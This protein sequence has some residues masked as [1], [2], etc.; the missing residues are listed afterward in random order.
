MVAADEISSVKTYV[1]M[2]IMEHEVSGEEDPRTPPERIRN[3][4]IQVGIWRRRR[5][6]GYHWRSVVII[7]VI[8]NLGARTRDRTFDR[9]L[10]LL[11]SRL[12][13]RCEMSR[14]SNHFNPIPVFLGN[15]FVLVGEMNDP[16]FVDIFVDDGIAPWSSL[17][18]GR[19]IDVQ[20]QLGLKIPYRLESFILAHLQLAPL[21]GE[22]HALFD[23]AHGGRR[24]GVPRD[25]TVVGLNAEG[26]QLVLRLGFVL[27]RPHLQSLHQ[28]NCKNALRHQRLFH[29]RGSGSILIRRRPAYPRS[30]IDSHRS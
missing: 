1:P 26:A 25:P 19:R 7:I 16:V 5:V 29:R 10:H 15:R 2:E 11:T 9:R 18:L 6:V 23:F 14:F 24:H 28:L 17:S 30:T 21:C 27:R 13:I 22:G 20:S 8:N 12:V 4:G 3:P